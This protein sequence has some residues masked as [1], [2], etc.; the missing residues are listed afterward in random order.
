MVVLDR[1]F[2]FASWEAHFPLAAAQSITRIG[3]DH[4]PL[5]V[6]IDNTRGVRSRIFRFEAAC[7]KQ[8]G[9]KEWLMSKWP[10]KQKH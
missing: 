2:M 6:E 4:N 9:F 3:S 7:L 5:I 10:E 1:I 8:E